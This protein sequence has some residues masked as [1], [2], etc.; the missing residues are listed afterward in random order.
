M[1]IEIEIPDDLHEMLSS[2]LEREKVEMQDWLLKSIIFKLT[3]SM[4][5]QIKGKAYRLLYSPTGQG[6]GYGNSQE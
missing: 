3:Y 4:N 1:K 5:Y 6:I 2:E